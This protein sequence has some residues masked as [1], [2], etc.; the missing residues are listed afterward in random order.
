[1]LTNKIFKAS[2][3]LVVFFISVGC[4]NKKDEDKAVDN[5]IKENIEYLKIDS[6]NI[7][8]ESRSKDNFVLV[9][10]DQCKI[11]YGLKDKKVV[12]I[13]ARP[14]QEVKADTDLEYSCVVRSPIKNFIKNDE[15][16]IDYLNNLREQISF[17][18][19]DLSIERDDY[20]IKIE[21]VQE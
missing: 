20:K 21:Q 17:Q 9:I 1:M 7:K 12:S 19:K 3:L 6:S 4:A 2:I 16:Y 11:E 15:E 18:F 14:A 8:E 13:S 10:D 5:L